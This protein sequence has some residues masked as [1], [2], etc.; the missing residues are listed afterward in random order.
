VRQVILTLR[1]FAKILEIPTG[2]NPRRGR[3][4]PLGN[5]HYWLDPEN[6]LRIAKGI[7][8]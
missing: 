4:P 1:G 8:E 5:P 2:G 7:S 6:G 3:R